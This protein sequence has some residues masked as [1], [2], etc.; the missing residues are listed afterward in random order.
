MDWR[1]VVAD[2]VRAYGLSDAQ[3]L[4]LLALGR[5][6]REPALLQMRLPLLLAGLAC[7]LCGLG[8][9]FAIAAN[10]SGLAR[11]TQFGLLQAALGLGVLG[12]IVRP[13]L[14]LP[15]GLWSLLAIGG[16]LAFFGQ[17]YQTGADTWQ[18]F[19]LWAGLALPLV[20]G[21]R[22][23][24]LW[25]GWSLVV[26]TAIALWV[27]AHAGHRWRAEADD[28]VVHLL[29]W[30]AALGVALA[31]HGDWGR[32]AGCGVWARRTA[33]CLAAGLV[34]ATAL[35]ALFGREPTVQA[36]LAL[37]ALGAAAWALARPDGFDL[38]NLSA[39]ALGLNVVLV[40]GLARLL[41]NGPSGGA[42]FGRFLL[43]GLAAAGLLAATVGGVLRL[44]RRPG[45]R[46]GDDL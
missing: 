27:A 5:L 20:L 17:T 25:A 38:F 43:L 2:G 11:A 42:P 14:C 21:L 41:F 4:E 35:A 6:D 46:E 22:S 33:A 12:V 39:V 8:L 23:D 26:M 37:L 31:L 36:L 40:G 9:I 44:A 15:L 29:G 7:L 30:L 1:G 10:W 16:L 19:A 24:V 32:R 45:S 28:V 3:R 34:T 18:L 13:S